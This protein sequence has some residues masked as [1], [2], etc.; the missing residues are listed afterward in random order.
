MFFIITDAIIKINATKESPMLLYYIKHGNNTNDLI[1][2]KKEFNSMKRLENLIGIN[3]YSR[4]FPIYDSCGNDKFKPYICMEKVEGRT[5]YSILNSKR[6]C[7]RKPEQLLTHQQILHIYEQLNTAFSLL[8]KVGIIYLDL[9]PKN[10][11]VINNNYDIKLIDFT[12]CYYLDA[13]EGY[14]Q[15][16]NL[17]LDPKLPIGSQLR[18]AG[19]LLF[20]NLFFCDSKQYNLT[21]SRN[22]FQQYG[23]LLNCIF[24]P[25]LIPINHDSEPLDDWDIWYQLLKNRIG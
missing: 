16:I 23:N 21:E 8:Q 25:D 15:Q 19:A 22:F 7:F 1:A 18:N 24:N 17:N 10:I 9:N 11:L 3:N 5:L 13:S 6:D 20:T 4:F 2:F 12:N 14:Y